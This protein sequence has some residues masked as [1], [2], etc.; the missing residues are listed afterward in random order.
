MLACSYMDRFRRWF[1]CLGIYFTMYWCNEAGFLQRLCY[2]T[3]LGLE[4][5]FWRMRV[6][7]CKFFCRIYLSDV[8]QNGC[9]NPSLIALA[10]G[11]AP[12]LMDWSGSTGWCV[13]GSASA[14]TPRTLASSRY[15]KTD[16]IMMLTCIVYWMF[17]LI[18]CIICSD[19][20]FCLHNTGQA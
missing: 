1:S 19:I 12:T 14:A 3:S 2:G 9:T 20:W 15:A 5:L 17:G 7:M 10:A 13:A 16:V 6:V 8:L 18:Y 4:L 11:S